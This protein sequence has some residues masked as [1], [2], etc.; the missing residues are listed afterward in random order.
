MTRLSRMIFSLLH[1]WGF[2]FNMDKDNTIPEFSLFGGPLHRLGTCLG[3]LRGK[4]NTI[5]LGLVLGFLAWVVLMLL[6]FFQGNVPKMFSL[7][8]I[9]VHVRLLVAIPLFFF[10]ETLVA[11]RMQD[12]ISN[13]VRSDLI[14]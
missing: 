9:N 8:V 3:L 11:P 14:P 6:A 10:C 1:R 12:F 5:R 2:I 4:T 13:I 7:G